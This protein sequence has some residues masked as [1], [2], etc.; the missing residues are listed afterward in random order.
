M[1]NPTTAPHPGARHSLP[2]PDPAA[3]AS[4]PRLDNR[5]IAITGAASGLGRAAASALAAAGATTILVDRNL[6]GLESLHDAIVDA[7]HPQ[8][9]LHAM[10]FEG[11]TINDYIE[12]ATA[13][14]GEFHQL[15]GLLHC[16]A[17]LGELSP[18]TQYDADLWG[19]ALHVNLNAP[20]ILNQVL[21]P[22][23]DRS[24]AGRVVFVTD[25]LGAQP[26]A[27][28]GAYA[29]SKAALDAMMVMLSQ[30]L[31]DNARV[32]VL[33]LDP[34]V[35][36]TPLRRRAFPAEAAGTHPAP[37]QVAP[38]FVSLFGPSGHDLHGQIVCFDD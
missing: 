31:G 29:V 32:R 7:G 38:V 15:D 18:L 6:K 26:R 21:L 9:V 14:D 28:W 36:D 22:L 17:S 8:P 34:G 24:D 10:H 25:A 16:A 30:E 5:L 20:F 23:L 33:G 19:R 2:R 35:M 13:I 3:V 11:A 4:L 37:E 12:F 1:S 27:F